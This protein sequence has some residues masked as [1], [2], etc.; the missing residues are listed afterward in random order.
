MKKLDI[1][2]LA[3]NVYQMF[4][5]PIFKITE[6]FRDDEIY[7]DDEDQLYINKIYIY[8]SIN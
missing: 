3:I 6:F 4:Q 7:E 2:Q 5:M 1:F 8:L